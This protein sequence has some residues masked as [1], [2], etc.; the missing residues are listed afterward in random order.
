MET[1]HEQDRRR[2][3]DELR[4]MGIDPYSWKGDVSLTPLASIYKEC[5]P[6]P[7]RDGPTK[8]GAGRITLM[9]GHGKLIF[10]TF[11]DPSGHVQLAFDKSKFTDA[12]WRILGLLDLGDYL[13][14]EGNLG[15]TKT[16]EPTI[17]ATR[18][19]IVS[20]SLSPLPDKVSGLADIEL[21]YRNRHLD[22]LNPEV[23]EVMQTRSLILS[24]IRSFMESFGYLEVET[25]L[26]QPQ[27]GGAAAKPFITHHNALET[28][29]YLRIAPELYLKRLLIGNMGRVFE[30]GK[31]FRNEGLSTRHNPEFT[32][33][34]AY[35]PFG[36]YETMMEL[37]QNLISAVAESINI[38]L[39]AFR[40]VRLMDLLAERGFSPPL[41]DATNVYEEHVEPTLM[42]PTFVTHFPADK[43]PLAKQSQE[44]ARFAE[45][46]ELAMGGME[47]GPGYTEQNDPDIQLEQFRK[48]KEIDQDFIDALKCGMPPAGGVGI[49]I[50]RLIAVLLK[51]PNI[52]DVILFPMLRPMKEPCKLCGIPGCQGGCFR[53]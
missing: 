4:R 14:V 40:R 29:L 48:Q 10:L 32:V 43:V 42:E 28:N 1:T 50:D 3:L 47:I 39:P 8:V 52:R 2:K 6:G 18:F 5:G 7:H 31:N 49:G 12:Q 35:A 11:A 15:R 53:E 33:M 20:K 38:T 26:M 19:C 13:V 16:E 41:E 23:R 34:E 51:K 22:L 21:R 45:M 25:P 17:W 37:T 44:D 9:R 30:I 24:K 27:A 36:N 46:F